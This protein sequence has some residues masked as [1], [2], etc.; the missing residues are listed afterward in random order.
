MIWKLA[1]K[2]F[3]FNLIKGFLLHISYS[4]ESCTFGRCLYVSSGGCA[5][6]K[7]CSDSCTV[8]PSGNILKHA[9]SVLFYGSESGRIVSEIS[10]ALFKHKTNKWLCLARLIALLRLQ[11]VNCVPSS[12]VWMCSIKHV[13]SS[14]LQKVPFAGALSL[15]LSFKSFSIKTLLANKFCRQSGWWEMFFWVFFFFWLICELF[16]N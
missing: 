12:P 8:E 13:N 6:S 14:A 3:W 5:L 7:E 1:H 15:S 11:V 10:F 4:K 16:E 9:Y 2:H